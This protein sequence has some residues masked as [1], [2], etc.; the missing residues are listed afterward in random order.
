MYIYDLRAF[1]NP[2]SYVEMSVFRNPLND[3]RTLFF[4]KCNE[5]DGRNTGTGEAAKCLNPPKKPTNNNKTTT[6]TRL[7][8]TEK[9]EHV[10]K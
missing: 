2:V 8:L 10:V 6:H 9:S 4:W 1:T 5:L 3:F 7:S